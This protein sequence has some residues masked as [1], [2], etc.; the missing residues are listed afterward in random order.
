MFTPTPS[1]LKAALLATALLGATQVFAADDGIVVYNAQHESLTKA[2]V[3]GFT[4]ETGIKVT[5]RNGDDTE[6]GNQIVQEGAASPA[7]VF[8]TENSPAMVLVD[9]AGL[10]AP[11]AP[12]T[13]EQV[14]AAYRP[15]HGKWVGIAARST[16]FVYNPAKLPEADLPKS[17]MDLAGPAWK[18]RWGA[19][20]AGAD[21]Q[22]IVA[23]VLELKG[24]AAT[25]EWLK[26]MK[27]NVTAYRGN[28]AVLKA[29][30]AGQIDSGVIYHYYSFGDQAKTGENSNNTA[31]H[32]FKHKDPG[33]FVSVSGGG[34]LASSKH[35]EQAQALLKWITGKDGQD[36]LKTGKSFEYAVGKNAPS[37]PK[38]VP[39]SQLDAPVVDASKLD[40]KKAVD[41]M[42]QAGLL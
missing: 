31:L 32:Y 42:T 33:A 26:G 34:V 7:D 25:L 8:L 19:S 30:N 37:N 3:E 40:S 6:M 15:A 5:V 16:V 9:N 35:K 2:W 14:E 24:E 4:K 18:G 29:V 21:F 1:F 17:L 39:L 22:A 41:L 10:F 11:V 12:T 20:P 38:L 27:S 36:I 28:S 13:L 23:A